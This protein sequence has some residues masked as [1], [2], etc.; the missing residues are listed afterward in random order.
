[1]PVVKVGPGCTERREGGPDKDVV[2]VETM[3]VRVT[4][5][6]GY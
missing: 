2:D 1:M 5:E 4:R 3:V 6:V